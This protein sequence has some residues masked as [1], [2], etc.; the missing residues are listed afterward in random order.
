MT[1]PQQLE[2]T[3]ENTNSAYKQLEEIKVSLKFLLSSL[4][5][6][7]KV[8][9]LEIPLPLFAGVCCNFTNLKTQFT[10]LLINNDELEKKR[11]K[12]QRLFLFES[13][14]EK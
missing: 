9:I 10:N 3:K 14:F 4:K 7:Q 12:N 11:K 1:Q 5:T 2:K 8:H 6:K 13:F